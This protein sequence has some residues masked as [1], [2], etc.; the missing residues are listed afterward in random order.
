M[1]DEE[2]SPRKR[3]FLFSTEVA[4]LAG[5]IFIARLFV[6]HVGEPE[7]A[8]MRSMLFLMKWVY[9]V[10]ASLLILLMFDHILSLQSKWWRG[11]SLA[12]MLCVVVLLDMILIV[13]EA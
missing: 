13:L 12:F 3:W 7:F 10:A 9:P 2:M 5:N 1:I 8:A 4:L 6:S 11:N